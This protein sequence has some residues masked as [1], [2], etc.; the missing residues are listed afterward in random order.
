M[1]FMQRLISLFRPVTPAHVIDFQEATNRVIA[2]SQRLTDIIESC[3]IDEF[4][5]DITGGHDPRQRQPAKQTRQP[6]QSKRTKGS[7]R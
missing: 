2:S 4:A 7:R 6:R 5:A 3:P 1:T